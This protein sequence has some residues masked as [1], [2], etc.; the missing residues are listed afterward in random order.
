[1][2]LSNIASIIMHN[3]NAAYTYFD[4]ATKLFAGL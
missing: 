1:M 3:T 4:K 2:V